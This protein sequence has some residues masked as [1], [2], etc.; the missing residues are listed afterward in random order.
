[1]GKKRVYWIWATL[2][3]LLAFFLRTYRIDSLTEFLGDQGRDLLIVYQAFISKSIPLSGPTVLTGQHLGPFFY[4]LI[5][6]PLILSNF[7]PLSAAVFMAFL[8]SVSAVLLLYI[9]TEIFDF[10]IGVFIAL[11]FTVSPALIVQSRLIWEP[12]PIPFFVFLFIISLVKVYKDR[13][14]Y[15]F[16]LTGITLGILIQLHY[17]DM[18]LFLPALFIVFIILKEKRK[19]E[20][21]RKIVYWI[22]GGFVCFFLTILPFILYEASNGFSDI[23]GLTYFI[24]VGNTT[25]REFSLLYFVGDFSSRLF[26]NLYPFYK[27][28]SALPFV[29]LVALVPFY[30]RNFWHLFFVVW[31]FL[32]TLSLALYRGVVFNHYLNFLIPVPFLLLGAFLKSIGNL[33]LRMVVFVFLAILVFIDLSK[34]DISSSG[35]KDLSRVDNLT[36]TVIKLSNNKPYSFTLISSNSF[37]DLHYR[38]FLLIKKHVPRDIT[39]RDY[40]QL[41]LI[42]EK[43]PC[44]SKDEVS[45][46]L[47][48]KVLCNTSHCEQG[49]YPTN[50]NMAQ[51]KLYK[52]DYME[53]Y[54]IYSF[55]RL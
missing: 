13:R 14:F 16:L 24:L 21:L 55:N 9:G 26:Q 6:I 12:T 37:S 10:W 31:L 8:G 17:P 49:E 3:F 42:C 52:I 5:S 19:N 29:L 40:N 11:I 50:I 35:S 38:Y 54:A 2:I 46:T 27:T 53:N 30:R 48:V 18:F 47:I 20:S 7:N 34:S 36:N 23:K 15:F 33:K 43:A 25:P 44:P 22:L 28:W 41:F 32:G 45:H 39:D 51:W 4:Y 1:M